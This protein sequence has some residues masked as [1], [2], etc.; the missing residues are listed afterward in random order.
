MRDIDRG[1]DFTLLKRGDGSALPRG[2]LTPE[3][4]AAVEAVL[5]S[6]AAPTPGPDGEPDPR[7]PG[8]RRHDGLAEAMR[9]L[10]RGGLPAAGGVPVTI[11]ATTTLAEWEAR[12]ATTGTTRTGATSTGATLT[13]TARTGHGD[14]WTMRTTRSAAAGGG[15][16]SGDGGGGCGGDADVV[17]VITTDAGG[18]LLLGRTQ[19]LANRAQR[20][21]L[22]ARDGGCCFPDCTRP[23]A[24]T[25]VHH[26]VA[27]AHG[28]PTDI[29]N[30]CLLAPTTTGTSN[31]PAGPSTSLPM[32]SRPGHHHPGSTPPGSPAATPHTTHP[33]SPSAMPNRQR[34]RPRANS[35]NRPESWMAR[36]PERPCQ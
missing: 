21:A 9:R 13:G 15:D 35:A 26:V 27:W 33:T 36:R 1:R 12:H 34:P 17:P 24:W 3:A 7:T 29:T 4:T 8:Q 25:E 6:L 19:R 5:D 32:A 22:A 16:C 31:E 11:L 2:L 23:A 14:I 28:G 18:V 20:L 30:L 10:L